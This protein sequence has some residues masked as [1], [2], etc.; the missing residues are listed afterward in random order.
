MKKALLLSVVAST[1]IMAGGDIAPVEPVVEAPVVEASGWDFSGQAVVYYQTKDSVTN[2]LFDQAASKAN[3]GLQLRAVNKDLFSGIGAGVELTGLGTLGL[4]EDVVSGTM[5]KA[6]GELNGAAFTQAYLTY[7]TGN[8]SI[9]IGRQELPKALSPFAFSESW[10]VFKTGFEAVL[11]VN[12]DMT[13]TTLVGA[14]VNKSNSHGDLQDFRHMTAAGGAAE[15][16][17][18]VYM[19]TAQNKSVENL[20]LTG[21]WYYAPNMVLEAD[22]VHVLW[23]DGKYKAGDYSVALQGGTIITDTTGV[24]DTTAF[25]A[26]IGG[27]FG[28]FDASVAYSSV[29]DGT[30]AIENVGT[31]N[32]TPLYTQMIAN[33]SKIKTDAD[34]VV[35]RIG[36]KALDGKFGLAYG[37]TD[38]MGVDYSELDLTFKTKV[39]DNTTLFAGYIYQDDDAA[40]DSTNTLRFWAK[41]NF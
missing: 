22:D 12:T 36:V 16:C 5:Q 26:K 38:Y 27:N 9:K 21:S 29:D 39:G 37:Y 35:G 19:L 8:T 41:Y 24:E 34:T 30:A 7:G 14:Y 40:A 13:D 20:T 15:A 2:D 6:D 32:K 1:M 23:A 11:V 33:Q 4:E 25:G 28:D 10:N 17:D 31:N 18:G 3:V